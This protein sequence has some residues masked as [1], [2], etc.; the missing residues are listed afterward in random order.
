MEQ[1]MH[2]SPVL[3]AI[4]PSPLTLEYVRIA[5]H[6]RK[7]FRIRPVAGVQFSPGA[8]SWIPVVFV[9]CRRDRLCRGVAQDSCENFATPRVNVGV[10]CDGHWDHHACI[11]RQSH[12]HDHRLRTVWIRIHDGQCSLNTRIQK[13]LPDELRGRVMA[14]WG[15]AFVGSRPLA[16]VVNGSLADNVSLSF[17]LIL[18]AVA[19]LLVVPIVRMRDDLSAY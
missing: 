12:G 2:L 14:L 11:R 1:T 6:D 4:Q 10:R 3:H 19:M 13:R 5:H 18:V 17:T 15:M 9:R 16:A 7:L 8:Y